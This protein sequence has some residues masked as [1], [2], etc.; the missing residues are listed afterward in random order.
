MATL[1]DSLVSSSARKLPVRVRPDLTARRQRYQ[2]QHYW[3][4][5]EPVRMRYFRLQ[6]EEYALL[7]MLDGQM[8]LDALKERFEA[9]FPPHKIT[10]E[11]LQQ[12]IGMLHKCG[13]VIAD[14]PGQ[15]RQLK[16]RGDETRRKEM[17]GRVSNVLAIR[18]RG[19]DPQRMLDR[20]Y[21]WVSWFFTRWAFAACLLLIASALLTVGVRFA[22]FQASLPS[23]HQFFGPSNWFYLAA[24]MGV[25]KVMHEFGHG[26]TCRHFKGECHELGVMILVLTPCLYVNVSDS[27][28]L[29]NKWHRAA[30]AAAGMYVELVLASIATFVW[31]NSEPTGMLNN[32]ALST[33]TVCSVSTL[34]FNGNPLLRYDGYYIVSDILEIPNLHEKSSKLLKRKLSRWCLGFKEQ[35]DPFMPQRNH[36]MFVTFAVAAILYRWF[37]VLA[38]LFFLMK[39]FEPYGLQI[40]GQTIACMSL[41]SLAGMP[42]WKLYK[43]LTVPGRIHQV[44]KAN[45]GATL[46]ILAVIFLVIALVPLPHRVYGPL[47]VQPTDSAKLYVDVPGRLEKLLVS[48]GEQVQAGQLVAQLSDLDMELQVAELEGE[49]NEYQT[50]IAMLAHRR[51]DDPQAALEIPHLR[52]LLAGVQEKLETQ[53]EEKDRLMM[54]AP[55]AGTIMPGPFKSAEERDT[56]QLRQWAGSIFD[57]K[58]VGAVL[59][60]GEVICQVGDPRRMEALLVVDQV[61]IEF[62]RV[63]QEV[64]IKFDHLPTRTYRGEIVEISRK[65]L[66]QSPQRLSIKAGGELATETDK[67]G[68]ERPMSTSYQARVPLDGIT[69]ADLRIGLRGKAKIHADPLSLGSRIWRTIARTFRFE[70]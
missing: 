47:E 30:I 13:L 19:I 65:E 6:E 38:I 15:G 20:V 50:Q 56:G 64:E 58:N 70:L 46:A 61:D 25:T 59:Q 11:E 57:E 4:V 17:L 22:E 40:V 37:V 48:P 2:G 31:F 66:T 53:L 44:K 16:K 10:V 35:E 28:L 14:V 55:T 7:Y 32:I 52:T 9:E 45:F 1:A 34:L 41:F 42:L 39:V 12:F 36:G 69:D 8:S 33:M 63:G 29:P 68:R 21:P 43:H 5:K 60:P 54:R 27:W 23:F 67:S 3:V 26:L 62:V 49:R 51:F 24:A 18:F